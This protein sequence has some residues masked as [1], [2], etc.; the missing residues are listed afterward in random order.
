MSTTDTRSSTSAGGGETFA[1][2][3]ASDEF[4]GLKRTLRRF[5][6]P[7]TVLFLAWYLLYVLLTAY[8]RG[9]MA[10]KVV[11]EVNVAYVFGLLQF[12]STFAI[13]YVYS[14]YADRHFDPTADAIRHRLEGTVT[15]TPHTPTTTT[16]TT[17]P[18]TIDLTSKTETRA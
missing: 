16:T 6:F 3:Q 10:D 7:A 17:A 2:V 8:A 13:A 12:V 18:P 9:F 1:Q 5:V 14:Q 11:G 15:T 4:Q